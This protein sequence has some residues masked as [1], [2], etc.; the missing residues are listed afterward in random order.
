MTDGEWRPCHSAGEEKDEALSRFTFSDLPVLC[1]SMTSTTW[2]RS[3]SRRRRPGSGGGGHRRPCMA[4]LPVFWPAIQYVK[5]VLL[6]QFLLSFGAALL[7]G[8]LLVHCCVRSTTL[9]WAGGASWQ[10]SAVRV[11]WGPPHCDL[12]WCGVC[13]QVGGCDNSSRSARVFCFASGT[14]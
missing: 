5:T 8:W 10:C 14:N 13:V 4:S 3:K 11:G 7:P 6:P 1:T 12:V 9:S 2:S